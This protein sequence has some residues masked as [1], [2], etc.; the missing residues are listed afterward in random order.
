MFG[1]LIDEIERRLG[2]DLTGDL[3]TDLTGDLFTF[4]RG[5]NL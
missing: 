4:E 3:T 2:E 1:E 5:E